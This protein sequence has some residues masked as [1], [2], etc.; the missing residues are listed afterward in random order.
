MSADSSGGAFAAS[1]EAGI[2][3]PF[4][5]WDIGLIL[6]YTTIDQEVEG[7][8]NTELGGLSVLL[9]AGYNF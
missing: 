5:S 4:N 1:L 7:A 2:A 3:I 8:A 6:K 9:S